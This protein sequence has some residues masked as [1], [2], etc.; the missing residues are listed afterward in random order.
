LTTHRYPDVVT[1]A[2]ACGAHVVALLED[3][4]SKRGRAALAISGGSSPKPMYAYFAKSKLDWNLVHLFWVDERG[5]PPTDKQSNFKFAN[6]NWLAAAKYPEANIHRVQAELDAKEAA[7]LYADDLARFFGPGIP[8][9]DAMHLGMGPDSHTASL[10]PGEPMI[11]DHTGVTAAV[12]V[13]KMHQFRI[14]LLPGVI[15]AARN[16]VVLVAGEDKIPALQSVL[17]DPRDPL[18]APAQVIPQEGTEWFLDE[19][20]AKGL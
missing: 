4:I 20:A 10:F 11:L 14:T 7:R 12:W 15:A 6:E 17:K 5:V 2:K 8:A 18:K 3:A 9:F 16:R 19:A 13:E 1:A